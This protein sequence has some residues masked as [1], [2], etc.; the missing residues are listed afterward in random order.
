MSWWRSIAKTVLFALACAAG[1]IASPAAAQPYPSRPVRL[2]VALPAGTAA[3]ITARLVGARMGETLGQ[4]F[5]IENRPGGGSS[6]GAAA[7]ARAPAD[8]Y[9]LFVA[10]ITNVINATMNPSLPFDFAKDFAAVVLLTTT[11]TILVVHPSLGVKTVAEFV[12]RAR[13]EPNA[14]S[15]GSSGPN[16][17]THLAIELLK[18]TADVQVTHIPYSG[19]PQAVTN[20]LAGHIQALFAP[21]STVLEHARVGALVALASTEGKRTALAPNLPTMIEAGFPDFSVGLWTGLVAPTGTPRELIDKVAQASN[22]AIQSQ[23]VIN[24]LKSFGIDM[25]G[26]SPDQFAQ[27]IDQEMR[28][29]NGVVTAA[30][31]RK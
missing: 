2:V 18:K 11:P 4:Q 25:V 14:I 8:G 30:G 20:L 19:S 17:T 28:R 7:A 15:F 26:G 3:D 9:T 1:L 13:S 24:G 6:L 5:I 29:W 16:T 23:E 10:T 27:Y 31:L 21:A 12:A 22:E